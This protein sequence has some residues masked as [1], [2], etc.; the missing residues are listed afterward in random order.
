MTRDQDQSLMTFSGMQKEIGDD[1][2]MRSRIS[3]AA[4]RL[5]IRFMEDADLPVRYRKASSLSGPKKFKEDSDVE[6]RFKDNVRK[7]RELIETML[8]KIDKPR[9]WRFVDLSP[10]VGPTVRKLTESE[11]FCAFTDYLIRRRDKERCGA[12]ELGGLAA[13]SVAFQREIERRI[14]SL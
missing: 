1:E 4:E 5:T 13:L 11:D 7:W 12:D 9:A 6:L 8:D 10:E 14:S 2:R 3:R